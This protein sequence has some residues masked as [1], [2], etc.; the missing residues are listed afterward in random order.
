MYARGHAREQKWTD[1]MDVFGPSALL[2]RMPL[3]PAA[4]FT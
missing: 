1:T 4:Q 3:T 2:P